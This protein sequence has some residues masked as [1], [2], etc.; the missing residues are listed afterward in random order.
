MELELDNDTRKMRIINLHAHRT[1]LN[2]GTSYAHRKSQRHS[3][4]ELL[5]G[6]LY[7]VLFD[8]LAFSHYLVLWWP[9]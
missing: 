4:M 8:R 1:F 6:V 3:Y 7:G 2:L 5:Y 9:L